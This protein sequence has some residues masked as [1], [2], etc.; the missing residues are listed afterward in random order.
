MRWLTRLA[1]TCLMAGACLG[2]AGWLCADEPQAEQ[3]LVKGTRAVAFRLPAGTELPDRVLPGAMVDVT[4]AFR[5]P[6]ETAV[7]LQ[8]V[9]VLAIDMDGNGVTTVTVRVTPLQATV[10][11]LVQ[12][13]GAN[14]SVKLR[15]S[16]KAKP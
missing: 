5:E 13:D 12:K 15:P 14:L 8:N 6:I 11:A 7:A 10:L 2:G 1:A 3:V 16:R 9:M 4:A